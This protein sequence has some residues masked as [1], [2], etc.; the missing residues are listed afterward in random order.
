MW[1]KKVE[2]GIL[3]YALLMAAVFS[4]LLQFYLN[5]QVSSQ[6]LQLFNME[7]TEAY[8]MAVLTKAT[9]KDDSGE[10][11]FEQG[12]AVYRR[13]GK[14]LEISSQLSSGHSYSFTFSTSKKDEG[15]A[16]EDKKATDKKEKAILDE[17]GKSD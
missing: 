7:R 4:L 3:L 10:M 2:A 16:K 8:A 6:R 5:R 1:K 11:E 17:A 14:N 12:K 13:Q 15:K 9:A